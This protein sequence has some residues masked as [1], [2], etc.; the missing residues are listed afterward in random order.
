MNQVLAYEN[1]SNPGRDLLYSILKASKQSWPRVDGYK[2]KK[3]MSSARSYLSGT[4]LY[5]VLYCISHSQQ[6][7]LT[8]GSP[9][10]AASSGESSHGSL[11]LAEW[12]PYNIPKSSKTALY[13]HVH[14]V[15]G[16]KS[17]PLDNVQSAKYLVFQYSVTYC[18][19]WSGSDTVLTQ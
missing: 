16:K 12:T 7:T 1:S 18:S 19:H 17:S 15:C 11:Y 6:T 4:Y 8:R 14:C 3:R 10:M 13:T 9:T 5:I 2:E